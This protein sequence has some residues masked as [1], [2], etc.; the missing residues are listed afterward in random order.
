MRIRVIAVGTRM[1][2]WVD[3]AVSD[4]SKRLRAPWRVEWQ[5]I[6][7]GA[8]VSGEPVARA[9]AQEGARVLEA[10]KGA[11][12]P[13]AL[14]E[15]GRSFTTRELAAWLARRAES[16]G[17]LALLIGGP[18]GHAPAVRS[19]ATKMLCLSTLTLP[20][21]LVRVVLAEQLYR[22]QSVLLNHPY[23]RD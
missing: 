3:S 11:V 10:L 6:A 14:D 4:Y 22:A 15:R 19:V 23:H 9:V 16:L 21:A 2:A 13:V 20:H 17:E 8:R 5:E 7:V 18:D 1:P 12:Q